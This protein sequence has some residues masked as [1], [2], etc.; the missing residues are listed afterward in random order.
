MT[1]RHAPVPVSQR[2]PDRGRHA[3]ADAPAGRGE[4]RSGPDR[5]EPLDLLGHGDVDSL[6]MTES[7]GLTRLSAA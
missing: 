2:D 7:G 3:P 6:T 4:E 1:G 5:R